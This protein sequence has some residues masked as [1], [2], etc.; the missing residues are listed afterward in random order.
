MSKGSVQS[1]VMALSL[2]GCRKEE[3]PPAE[4]VRAIKTITVE[5]RGAS[6]T[7]RYSGVVEAVDKS[8][9]SF[10]VPGNVKDVNVDVGD[11]IAKGQVI[12]TLDTQTFNLD[13]EAAQVD[14]RRARAQLKE[15]EANYQRYKSVNEES[16]GAVS[17]SS[18]DEAEAAFMSARENVTYTRSQ[19]NL[20]QRD[21][22]KTE[23]IAPFDGVV[24]K[25]Y[26]EP[27]FEVKRGDPIFDVF[28]EGGMEIATSI[29]ETDIE[30]I[31]Q[32][33]GCNIVFPIDASITYKGIVSEIGRVAE[34]ANAF[35]I[36]V[37]ILTRD[38]QIRPG[39]TAEVSFKISEAS[40]QKAFLIPLSALVP[41]NGNDKGYVFVYEEATSTV[42]RRPIEING[43]VRGNDLM[44]DGGL[45]GGEII[46]VAGVRFLEDGQKVKLMATPGERSPEDTPLPL[47]DAD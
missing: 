37:N 11:E 9:L 21:L 25:R 47:T 45:E 16:P 35:P 20:K 31:Y 14:L 43:A 23:L 18:V 10:E 6:Q 8:S 30:G 38:P 3:P 2:A 1:M 44:V 24:A 12:A 22:T 41:G 5:E 36:K 32:G 28:A 26:V 17:Q 29:P 4:R 15:K 39:M 33:Q 7:R 40:H 27:F 42:T 46:A 13:V 34:T 19:L